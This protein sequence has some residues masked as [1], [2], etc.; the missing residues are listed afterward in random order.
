VYR[1]NGS[2]YAPVEIVFAD[3]KADDGFSSAVSLSD[4]GNTLAAGGNMVTGFSIG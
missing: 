4:D 2:S 3:G 1:W